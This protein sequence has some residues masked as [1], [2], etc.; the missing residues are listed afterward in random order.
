MIRDNIAMQEA[1]VPAAIIL[2]LLS[3][4]IPVSA[5]NA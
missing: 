4:N 1:K 5:K 2:T 3:W